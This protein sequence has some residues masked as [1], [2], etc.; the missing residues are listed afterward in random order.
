M[1]YGSVYLYGG[2]SDQMGNKALLQF[3]EKR[4]K[5]NC[6]NAIEQVVFELK[7]LMPVWQ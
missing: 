2:K 5:D 4:W 1:K 3:N 7:R 6:R